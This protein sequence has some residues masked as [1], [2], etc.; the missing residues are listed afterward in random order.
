MERVALGI[1]YQ[2]LNRIMQAQLSALA[3][4]LGQY[5]LDD[6]KI[7]LRVTEA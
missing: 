5:F 7:S 3:I 6:L 1:C 2:L 4:H